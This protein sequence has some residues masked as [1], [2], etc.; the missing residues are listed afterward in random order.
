MTNRRKKGTRPGD[1][2]IRVNTRNTGSTLAPDILSS[3]EELVHKALV[4]ELEKL[5]EVGFVLAWKPASNSPLLIRSVSV[6]DT[7]MLGPLGAKDTDSPFLLKLGSYHIGKKITLSW[8][9]RA[10]TEVLGVA[11]FAKARRNEKWKL[12][13]TTPGPLELGGQWK[14]S[15]DFE[16]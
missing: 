14:E 7:S 1:A 10:F 15:A 6:D 4:L 12:L 5:D 2:A 8:H 13:K 16:V 9:V 3:S 11:S